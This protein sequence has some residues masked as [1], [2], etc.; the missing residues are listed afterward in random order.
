MDS[1]CCGGSTFT[2]LVFQTI[3]FSRVQFYVLSEPIT[4]PIPC[5]FFLILYMISFSLLPFLLQHV[6]D[7]KSG[8]IVDRFCHAIP[9][10]VVDWKYDLINAEKWLD[11]NQLGDLFIY[12]LQFSPLF[13]YHS[14]TR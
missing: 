4:I 2:E 8:D 14:I 11:D 6:L 5:H 12:A 9:H 13:V 10:L 7:K 1:I 3:L